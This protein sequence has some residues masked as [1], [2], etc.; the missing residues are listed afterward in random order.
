[1]PK[2]WHDGSEGGFPSS[3]SNFNEV[4]G[5]R[6]EQ[7]LSRRERR[8]MDALFQTGEATAAEVRARMPDPPSYT[9]VR[10]M[11]GILEDKGLIEHRSE[12]RRYVY[13]PR[14]SSRLEG[15]SAFQGV[16]RVFFG[17]SLEQALAAHL[18]DPGTRL[19][20]KELARMRALINELEGQEGST[21]KSRKATK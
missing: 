11:L 16:L 7:N 12:G 17:G 20:E 4:D 2:N 5:M 15:R 8:L 13:K 14:L 21:R 10:T 6:S 1:M 3:G 19:D 18:S 9:A